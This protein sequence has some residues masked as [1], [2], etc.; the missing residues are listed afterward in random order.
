MWK[1]VGEIIVIIIVVLFGFYFF[2]HPSTKYISDE[3]LRER[4]NRRL[5]D[6]N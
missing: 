1:I 3:E 4:E 5:R 2:L 6:D